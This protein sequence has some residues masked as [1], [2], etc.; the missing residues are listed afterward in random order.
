MV[1]DR[2]PE[3][4]KLTQWSKYFEFPTYGT[5]R[6]IVS[7]R[8]ENGAGFFLCWVSNSLYINVEKFFSWMEMNKLKKVSTDSTDSTPL[9]NPRLD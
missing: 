3:Y 4:V 9:T 7:K 2:R 5:M 6:N 8:D 1:I